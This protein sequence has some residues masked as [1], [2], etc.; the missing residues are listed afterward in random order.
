MLGRLLKR[1][2]GTY[3]SG[4][5]SADAYGRVSRIQSDV[6]AG[7]YVDLANLLAVP[8]LYRAITLIADTIG[9]MPFHAYRN[10]DLVTPQPNILVKPN[11][12]ETRIDTISAMVAALIIYGNY[13]ALLGPDNTVTGYPDS[14]IPIAPER[15]QVSRREGRNYY[16]VDGQEFDADQILHIKNFTLPGQHFGMGLLDA[17]RQGI[18]YAVALQEYAARYFSGGGGPT[19]I[20]HSEVT[21]LTQEEA[22]QLKLLWMSTYGGRN[23]EP[24]VLNS[25]TK[26]ERLS[27]NAKDSQLDESRQNLLTDIANMVGV[28]ASY[29]G[30]PNASRTYTNVT[31]ENLQLIRYSLAPLAAR[32]EQSFT[33]LIPRGQYAKFE[34][35]GLLRG[36][37]KAR[38]DS[39]QIALTNGFL[40]ID[41]VRE[42]ED[43]R[44]LGTPQPIIDDTVDKLDEV[45]T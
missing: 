3:S 28:P 34:F 10:E 9:Q 19:G 21:D 35:E 26:F 17:Q 40:T 20:I 14:I 43:R 6:W 11:P 7:T 22:D 13:F 24:A 33:E 5:G 32:V 42:L 8:G 23:R 30:A 41:E 18:G 31:E 15:M 1:Q 25:T 38:Y 4:G 45:M 2:L 27:D 29:V 37:T 36:D 44:P 12:M 39:Y 16:T